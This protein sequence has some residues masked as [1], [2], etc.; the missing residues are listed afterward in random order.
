MPGAPE[1]Q[2][3]SERGLLMRLSAARGSETSSFGRSGYDGGLTSLGR[4]KPGKL[5]TK[6]WRRLESEWLRSRHSASGLVDDVFEEAGAQ[7]LQGL[8]AVICTAQSCP[9][10]A[11]AIAALPGGQG[12]IELRVAGARCHAD[13]RSLQREAEALVPSDW[14][15]G[16]GH[17]KWRSALVVAVQNNCR[18]YFQRRC[19]SHSR[20]SSSSRR[21]RG[22]SK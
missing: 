6:S 14:H 9:A 10:Q 18:Q 20:R 11:A 19:R 22:S 13:A 8:Q 5:R 17:T 2:P 21:R 16:A 7:G 12:A 1:A 15:E 4:K 3:K